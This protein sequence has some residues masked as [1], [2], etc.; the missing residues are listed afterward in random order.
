[1]SEER[2][3]NKRINQHRRLISNL[4]ERLKTIEL[5]VEPEGRISN[6]FDALE[7]HIEDLESGVNKRLDRLE[8]KSNQLAGKLDIIIEHLTHINDLPEE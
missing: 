3:Q 5:D 1:M 8:H 2:E 4:T 7:Q 6:G